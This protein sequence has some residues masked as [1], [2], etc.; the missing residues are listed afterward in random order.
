MQTL[1]IRWRTTNRYIVLAIALVLLLASLL[2]AC[3]PPKPAPSAPTPTA[4]AAS[5]SHSYVG[6]VVDNKTFSAIRGAKVAL[7]F[8]GA[9]PVVYTDSEG[10]FRWTAGCAWKR[11]AI[12]TTNA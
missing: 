2:A 8:Q 1:A 12:K 9:P 7:D 4:P 5:Q 3:V 6:R 10:V 11:M